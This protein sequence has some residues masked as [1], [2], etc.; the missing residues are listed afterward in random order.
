MFFNLIKFNFEPNLNK[1]SK[2]E[3]LKPFFLDVLQDLNQQIHIHQLLIF[4][5]LNY[6]IE[7]LI[8]FFIKCQSFQ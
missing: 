3:T 8:I 7:V 1:L 5:L 6:D 4:S 2:V